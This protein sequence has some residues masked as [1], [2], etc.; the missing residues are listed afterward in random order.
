M[1]KLNPG[2]NEIARNL[3]AQIEYQTVL[4]TI[5]A[6]E[7]PGVIYVDSKKK[8]KLAFAQFKQRTFLS[9]VPS[10]DLGPTL[11]NF[12]NISVREHCQEYDAPFFRLIVNQPQ[13]LDIMVDSLDPREPIITGYHCYQK[14]INTTIENISFPDDFEIIPVDQELINAPFPGREDLLDEMCS[15]RESVDAFLEKSFGVAAFKDD[16]LAGWCL[17]EYNHEDQ[18]EVGIATMPPYRRIGLAKA[19]ANE[20]SNQAFDNGIMKILW[21]CFESNLPSWKTALSAGFSLVDS[22]KVAMLYW[23]TAL[24]QAVHG[25]INFEQGKYEDAL[26]CYEKSLDQEKPQSWMAFNAACTSV[27]L[28]QPKFAI[29]YLNLAIDLGFADLDYLVA[30]K[31]LEPLKDDPKWGEIIF[32]VNQKLQSES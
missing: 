24:N 17:S 12:F 14:I 23:D 1:E 4:K 10:T 16:A 25:N 22:H 21:H 13:W 26:I 3:L 29:E 15:E 8:P 20:F 6:G 9:G 5:M 30:N 32:R 2:E 28:N 7:T 31:H 27:H 18:C 11:R 19:M